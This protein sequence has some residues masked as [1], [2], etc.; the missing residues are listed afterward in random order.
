[1]HIILG[2]QITA[3]LAEKYIV[4]ELDSFEVQGR[5]ST[6]SAFCLVEN[7]P[8]QELPQVDQYRD[9]HQQLIKNYRAANWKFCEDALEHLVGRWNGEV[10]SFYKDLQARLPNLQAQPAT[11]EWNPS[12]KIS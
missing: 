7:V 9:L 3:E 4:L 2:D 6:I 1:M 8:L 11:Q 12:F 10:D 5:D